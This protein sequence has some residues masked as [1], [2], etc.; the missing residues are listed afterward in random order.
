VDGRIGTSHLLWARA[1]VGQGRYQEALP[2]AEM[3]DTLL[4]KNAVSIN[5]KQEASEAHQVL[6]NLQAKLAAQ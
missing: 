2:H 3:A 4:A 1:L 6:G 5:A